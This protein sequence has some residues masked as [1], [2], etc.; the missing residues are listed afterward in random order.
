MALKLAK[1][2]STLHAETP[3]IL[4]F[5]NISEKFSAISRHVGDIDITTST[6]CWV[7]KTDLLVWE[8]V[9]FKGFNETPLGTV[10]NR[11]RF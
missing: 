2:K 8:E 1:I 4:H 9:H 3:Q 6:A 7:Q 11:H 10:T 5:P